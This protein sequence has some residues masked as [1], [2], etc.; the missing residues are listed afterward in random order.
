[1]EKVES[2]VNKHPNRI[3]LEI[4]EKTFNTTKELLM[5][6]PN[7]F[8]YACLS[9]AD[10]FKKHEDGTIFVDRDPTVFDKIITYY[11]S[12]KL[13]LKGMT[14]SMI[15][16]LKEDFD[17]YCIPVPK[18]LSYP[19][20]LVWDKN[21]SSINCTLSNKYLTVCK[22]SYTMDKTA[23]YGVI[24][25]AMVDIFTVRIDKTESCGYFRIGLT[26]G[27][28]W[29]IDGKDN[30]SNGWYIS[31]Q[32]EKSYS[33]S[34]VGYIEGIGS[35]SSLKDLRSPVAFKLLDTIT[36]NQSD[37]SIRFLHNNIDIGDI[38]HTKNALNPAT[39]SISNKY[40]R[41]FPAVDIK[42]GMGVIFTIVVT[43]FK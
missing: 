43:K 15:D 6:I 36:V 9:N 39:S 5:S 8:F 35:P 1:M 27:D 37:T 24:G 33:D 31:G 26:C 25:N 28:S 14:S 41:L 11:R 17:F 40:Q 29:E 2:S 38:L 7:T 18:E 23:Y 4:G 22:T 34:T 3:K 10:N 16:L 19:D 32:F 13:D 20:Y 12:G 42:G 30:V 21:K